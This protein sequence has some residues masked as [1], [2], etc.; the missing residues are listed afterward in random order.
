[1]GIWV[2]EH[3]EQ[4]GLTFLLWKC[5]VA[6]LQCSLQIVSDTL[7]L[8]ILNVND[9]LGV[10]SQMIRPNTPPADAV[11]CDQFAIMWS[12]SKLRGCEPGGTICLVFSRADLDHCECFCPSVFG[13]ALSLQN[14]CF[15]SMSPNFCFCS[16]Y[17][18]LFFSVTFNCLSLFPPSSLILFPFPFNR[19]DQHKLDAV[20]DPLDGN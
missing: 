17:F 4:T 16:F 13:S 18:P 10:W 2:S 12:I 1:M 11:Q 19:G 7:N 6:G 3:A 8:N 14:C 9:V 5:H 20:L 15:S